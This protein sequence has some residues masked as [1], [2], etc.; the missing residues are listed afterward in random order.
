[1][2]WAVAAVAPILETAWACL[3]AAEVVLE[4]KIKAVVVV[5]KDKV[6]REAELLVLG[7]QQVVVVP[8]EEVPTE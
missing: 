7:D 5:S 8:A 4:I 6:F 3:A 2:L 1:L